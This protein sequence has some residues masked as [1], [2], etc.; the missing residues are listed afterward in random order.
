MHLCW[1]VCVC[2]CV[3]LRSCPP[4]GAST[5]ARRFSHH[6]HSPHSRSVSPQ[7]RLYLGTRRWGAL[8][9]PARHHCDPRKSQITAE[10]RELVWVTLSCVVRQSYQPPV[11]APLPA[12]QDVLNLI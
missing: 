10:R 4:G 3:C 11:S 7:C 2:V 8:Q 12:R 9:S 1:P 6:L 5:C